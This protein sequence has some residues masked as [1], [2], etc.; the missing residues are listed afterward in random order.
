MRTAGWLRL[1]VR[2]TRGR[3]GF[4]TPVAV[5]ERVILHHEPVG[6]VVGYR[7]SQPVH[8]LALVY[9]EGLLY[10]HAGKAAQPRPGLLGS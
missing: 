6:R 9:R 7:I 2:S 4:H 10:G 1:I 5:A 8:A 3:C